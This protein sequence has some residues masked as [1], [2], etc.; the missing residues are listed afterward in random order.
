MPSV[1]SLYQK[2][3]VAIDPCVDSNDLIEKAIAITNDRN[4]IRLIHVMEIT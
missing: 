1:M 4:N 2:T 3:L